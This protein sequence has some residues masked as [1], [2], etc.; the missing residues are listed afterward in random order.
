MDRL[1]F[2]PLQS[3]CPSISRPFPVPGA[4]QGWGPYP[5]S[6]SLPC[7]TAGGLQAPCVPRLVARGNLMS[8]ACRAAEP[9]CQTAPVLAAPPHSVICEGQG[10]LRHS[11]LLLSNHLPGAWHYPSA[12][13]PQA[14]PQDFILPG[15]RSFACPERAGGA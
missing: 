8:R 13:L 1:H 14:A 9:G 11:V 2:L 5:S 7:P 10:L 6:R 3:V 12:P 4:C 15:G